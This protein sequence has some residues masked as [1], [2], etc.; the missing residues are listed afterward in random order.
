MPLQKR[1]Y[2]PLTKYGVEKLKL[3]TKIMSN[4]S[5]AGCQATTPLKS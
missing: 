3:T 1:F 4:F 5:K 2:Q